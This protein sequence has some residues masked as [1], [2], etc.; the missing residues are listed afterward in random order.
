MRRRRCRTSLPILSDTV[1]LNSVVQY[2]PDIDYLLEVLRGAVALV[3]DGGRIFVGDV[4]HLGLLRTFHAS[5]EAARAAQT[6]GIAELKS[7]VAGAVRRETELA[8]DPRFFVALPH[9]L[10]GVSAV[11]VLVKRGPSN[12]ELTRYRYDVVLH[13]RGQAP[14]S[15]T[16]SLDWSERSLAE[17]DEH[18]GEHQPDSVQLL[19]V[20]NQRL[21]EHQA[22]VELLDTLAPGQVANDLRC[23]AAA[24]AKPGEYPDTF[25][26]LGERHGYDVRVSWTR[27]AADGCFDVMFVDR[28][29]VS[30]PVRLPEARLSLRT[31]LRAYANDPT[32]AALTHQLGQRLREALQ[33]R[34]PDYMVPAAI[35][36]LDALPLSPAGK[37]DRHA[38]PPPEGRPEVAPFVAPRTPAERTLAAIWCRILGL[39]RVGVNDNFFAL[40]GDSI[41]SIQVIARAG[42]KGLLLTSRQVFER[43]T[44]AE[45]A[46]VVD[47]APDAEPD[48][49]GPTTVRA[50]RDAVA[51][52]DPLFGA[53]LTQAD[54]DGALG[55]LG[56]ESNVVDAYPL[57]PT[58]QG[59]LFHSIYEPRST[60]YV[61]TLGCRLLGALDID[62]FRAAWELM[63][64]R[65]AV[66]RSAF[67]GHELQTPLQAVLRRAI[68]PFGHH[69]W[70]GLPP[71]E[72]ETRLSTLQAS[73]ADQAFDVAAPPLMRLSLVR[74]GEAEHRLIWSCHHIL[75]DGWSIPVLLDE[76][77]AAYGALCRREPPPLAP[78]PRYRDYIAWLRQQDIG[79]AEHYWRRRLDGFT[80]PT[81]LG[82]ARPTTTSTPRE[83]Y[84]EHDDAVAIGPLE[85]FARRHRL[86]VNTLVQGAWAL[87][88]ARYGRSDDVVFGV[89]VAGR[90][91][92]L[93]EVERSVGL[94][95]NTLPLRIAVTPARPVA[96]WL[97]DVQARQNRVVGASI[98]AARRGAALERGA[99]RHAAVRQHRRVR[100]L[101]R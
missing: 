82:V 28:E 22:I 72:Q 92:E 42:R 100:E 8:I 4:R 24:H 79:A 53:E 11:E 27:A 63:I 1:I 55:P 50:A 33:L 16:E 51:K 6:F 66:L 96:H 73:D 21:A 64:E 87:L 34:L 38:L 36:T 85:R 57:S 86:T 15:V 71:A 90:P 93:A 101:S 52:S 10:P 98:H 7:L 70:R 40:G 74:T 81:S 44:I 97:R 83:R 80:A 88:L 26:A 46:A 67:V 89:T 54:L 61:T 41:Q 77:F 23:A 43:Q 9:H 31:S 17:L 76:V 91:A 13:V 59:M 48:G 30:V 47:A 58:Q 95:I 49:R 25:W 29:R 62:A 39:D 12:N 56:G 2:F 75:L 78:A 20:P 69:D 99:G 45:L 94:F 14:Q 5:V 84:A 3:R 68:L 32:A 37:V 18:L 35:V 19:G 60:A 65:H